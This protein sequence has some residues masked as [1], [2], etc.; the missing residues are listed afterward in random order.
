VRSYF[1]SLVTLP[2][3]TWKPF[4]L[5]LRRATTSHAIVGMPGYI[6]FCLSR[7]SVFLLGRSYAY[8]IFPSLSRS[9]EI[10]WPHKWFSPQKNNA[11]LGYTNM[12]WVRS[13]EKYQYN[14]QKAPTPYLEL[15]LSCL[16]ER[17]GCVCREGGQW[18]EN[19]SML[20]ISV[21]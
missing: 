11:F 21:V 20:K 14:K 3:S 13:V 16:I 5:P 6:I 1:V 19:S 18:E 4:Q 10:I 12:F 15:L 9:S 2:C 17:G 7:V 8:P